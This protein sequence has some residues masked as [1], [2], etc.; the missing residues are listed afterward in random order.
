MYRKAS[1]NDVKGI[2]SLMCDLEG[3][4]LPFESFYAIYREQLNSAGH[5]CLICVHNEAVL[6]VLNLR[7][8]RQLHHC[9]RI[10]EIMEFVVDA[11]CRNQGIGKEMLERAS[12]IAKE[13]GCSQIEAACN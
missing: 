1:L 7:F 2:Y 13:H 3:T 10:A 4:D 9:E 11:S 8:E 12:Q 6:A 5:Y